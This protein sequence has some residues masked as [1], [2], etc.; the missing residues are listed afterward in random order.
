MER[1]KTANTWQEKK[2][3][4]GKWRVKRTK[5]KIK[6]QRSGD[7]E[8]KKKRGREREECLKEK[9]LKEGEGQARR[10]DKKRKV[11]SN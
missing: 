4:K 9:L 10:V 6:K 7:G 11:L 8:E 3:M 1:E 2:A 5:E